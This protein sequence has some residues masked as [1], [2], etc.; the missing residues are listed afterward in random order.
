MNTILFGH[1]VTQPADYAK[2]LAGQLWRRRVDLTRPATASGGH[3]LSASL[4]DALTRDEQVIAVDAAALVDPALR[5]TLHSAD[6]Q[7]IYLRCR[8]DALAQRCGDAVEA[9]AF[10]RDLDPLCAAAADKVFDVSEL[11]LAN[12]LRHLIRQCM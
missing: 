4:R 12:G 8:P 3:D 11:Q 9:D 2:A 10:A 7:R 6:A 5:Q 1:R